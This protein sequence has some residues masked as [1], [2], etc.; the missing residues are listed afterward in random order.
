MMCLMRTTIDINDALLDSL[1]EYAKAEVRTL[2]KVVNETLERGLSS[3]S[4]KRK[5]QIRIMTH[6]QICSAPLHS[7]SVR[8]MVDLWLDCPHVR[9][10]QVSERALP[11]F[12]D[13]SFETGMGGNLS[14]N[15]L[16]AAHARE[17]S[18]T[19]Y[20]NDRDFA[21]FAGIK[22]MNPPS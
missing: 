5:K 17:N 11:V 20:C 4:T 3:S 21:R 13:L 8:A 19:I 10:I 18:A 16:I 1:K 2:S 14:T 22:C 12:F 7:E 15:A 9:I 6:P